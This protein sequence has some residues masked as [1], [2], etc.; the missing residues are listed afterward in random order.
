MNLQVGVK[1]LLKNNEGKILLL[2]RSLEKYGK[3]NG[4]W[5]IV[6]GRIDP[7]TS[8]IANLERETQE[9]TKLVITSKPRLIAAQDIIPN[10]ERHIVR[11]TYVAQTEGEP[12]LDLKENG[13]YKW[14]SF[15]ELSSEEDLDIYVKELLK[16]G[17][18]KASSWE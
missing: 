4:S 7:G 1:V 14:V 3:T 6:G 9:E 2:K 10:D 17:L 11:L 12:D 16:D 18:L 13:E 15:E 5:D 8:L